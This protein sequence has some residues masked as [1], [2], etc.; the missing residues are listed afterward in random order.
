MVG[1][2]MSREELICVTQTGSVAAGHNE[3]D[4]SQW[5]EY[6]LHNH[7]QNSI[8]NGLRVSLEPFTDHLRQQRYTANTRNRNLHTETAFL[9]WTKHA[10]P[11]AVALETHTWIVVK[12][13]EV[14]NTGSTRDRSPSDCLNNLQL[15]DSKRVKRCQDTS[16][17][18]YHLWLDSVFKKQPEHQSGSKT[19]AGNCILQN[20]TTCYI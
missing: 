7:L 12:L 19:L 14:R 1:H 5:H 11:W 2:E 17:F 10:F 20:Y 8:H 18:L 3:M 16:R 15:T 4:C 6:F 13:S 9:Q